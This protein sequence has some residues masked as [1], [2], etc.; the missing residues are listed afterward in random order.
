MKNVYIIGGSPISPKSDEVIPRFVDYKMLSMNKEVYD[1]G[2][3]TAQKNLDVPTFRTV[4]FSFPVSIAEQQRIVSILDEAFAGIA[5]ATANAEKNLA[6][7]RELFESYLQS[8]F[9]QKG[10]AWIETSLENLCD[11]KHGFA[12]D[13]ND[14]AT[15]TETDKLVVLTPGNFTEFGTL[16]FT[17]KN[18]KRFTGIPP[19]DFIFNRGDLAVVM[20]DLSSKMK[21]LGKPALIEQDGVL[22]NQRIGRL[23]FKDISLDKKL[24]YYFFMTQ[25]YLGNIKQSAT[26]T[27]VKHTAPKRILANNIIFPSDV[28]EQKAIVSKLDSL[29]TETKRL[30][31]AY[32]RKLVLLEKLKKSILNQAFSGQL[33]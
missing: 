28:T 33:Q 29:I 20:T 1:L 7:A 14:F 8:V 11:I 21:I 30:E 27:M 12:F 13:G 16:S 22:H 9:I 31:D 15:S 3:G 6:N 24:L 25:S 17:D 32:K 10:D 19:A 18:T 2:R 4:P 26:G 5:T 23:L